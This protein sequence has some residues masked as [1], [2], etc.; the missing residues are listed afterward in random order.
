[1]QVR[2]RACVGLTV[3]HHH[4]LGLTLQHK[5]DRTNDTN[6]FHSDFLLREPD[7]AVCPHHSQ[8]T[9]LESSHRATEGGAG[10][11]VGGREATRRCRVKSDIPHM[12]TRSPRPTQAPPPPPPPHVPD[13]D[14]CPRGD[15]SCVRTERRVDWRRSPGFRQMVGARRSGDDA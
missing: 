6:T 12:Q 9:V 13:S 3:L 5:P 11:G 14:R 4:H 2:I 10:G 1:M 7:A 8:I 15:A